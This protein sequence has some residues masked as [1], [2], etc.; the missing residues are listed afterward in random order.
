M[1]AHQNDQEDFENC[2]VKQS[3]IN[4]FTLGLMGS[5]L[6]EFPRTLLALGN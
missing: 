4:F 2:R 3:V 1:R 6:N 5:V